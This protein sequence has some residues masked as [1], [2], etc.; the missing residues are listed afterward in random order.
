MSTTSRKWMGTMQA[1][2]HT[3]YNTMILKETIVSNLEQQSPVTL[4]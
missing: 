3:H 1:H 2:T 4:E